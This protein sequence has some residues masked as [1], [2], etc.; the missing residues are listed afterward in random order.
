MVC[1]WFLRDRRIASGLLLGAACAIK[2]TAWFA[3]P[4]YLVYV[5][6]SY[7][8][9]EAVRRGGIALVGFLALNLPWLLISPRAWLSSLTLPM[10]L[11][12][13]PE[14]KGAIML[15]LSGATL[16]PSWVFGI[17]ELAVLA[18]ALAW[19]WRACRTYPFAGLPL[20]FLPLVFAWRSPERYFALLPALALVALILTLHIDRRQAALSSGDELLDTTRDRTDEMTPGFTV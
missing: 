9:R 18:L 13:F 19:Y 8:P 7:G 15:A 1:A 10:S 5:W 6:R 11:P 16:P 14:G 20:T 2:Q 4:F 3:A 12:L 17:L